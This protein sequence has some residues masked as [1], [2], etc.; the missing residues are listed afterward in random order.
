[1]VASPAGDVK[2]RPSHRGARRGEDGHALRRIVFGDRRRAYSFDRRTSS[3]RVQGNW[4]FCSGIN[5]TGECT[6]VTGAFNANGKWNDC[7]SS[8]RPGP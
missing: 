4:Y 2:D 1:M 7:I 8:A 5:Y 6:K 3:L